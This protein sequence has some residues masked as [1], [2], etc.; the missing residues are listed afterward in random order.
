MKWS[1]LKIKVQTTDGSLM[2]KLVFSGATDVDCGAAAVSC[3]FSCFAATPLKSADRI[4]NLKG[5]GNYFQSLS[6]HNLTD[7][8]KNKTV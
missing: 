7:K 5:W 3:F 4:K 2:N 6:A 8:H 1:V